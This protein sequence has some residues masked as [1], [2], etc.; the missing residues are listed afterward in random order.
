MGGYVITNHNILLSLYWYPV[1]TIS[2][3]NFE[4]KILEID[5][6]GGAMTRADFSIAYSTILYSSSAHIKDLS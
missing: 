5:V 4:I 2:C 1:T 6:P 3:P